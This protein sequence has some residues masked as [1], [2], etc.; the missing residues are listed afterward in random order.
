MILG[1]NNDSFIA[2]LIYQQCLTNLRKQRY[3]DTRLYHKYNQK[4]YEHDLKNV[5]GGVFWLTDKDFLIKYRTNWEGLDLLTELCQDAPIFSKDNSDP[6]QMPVKFQIMIWLYFFGH[7]GMTVESQ[8]ETLKTSKGLL[9]PAR[10]RV[11]YAF[12]YICDNWIHWPDSDERKRIASQIER[13]FFLPNW[14][15]IMDGTLFLAFEPECSDKADY[16]GHKYAYSITCNVLCYNKCQIRDYLAGFPGSSHNSTPE[17]G[18]L[19]ELKGIF[20][21][22]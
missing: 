2:L 13:E 16:H 10:D 4:I 8:C 12:N 20:F 17:Y 9:N 11:T 18:C 21:P 6:K 7:K 22:K 1:N 14:V 5:E 3:L 15:W 19:P